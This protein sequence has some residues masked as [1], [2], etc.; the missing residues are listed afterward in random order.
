MPKKHNRTTFSEDIFK[1]V[2]LIWFQITRK[3]RLIVH[4]SNPVHI[5]A[6]QKI[7][8]YLSI[9]SNEKVLKLSLKY[10]KCELFTKHYNDISKFLNLKMVSDKENVDPKDKLLN[11]A[12]VFSTYTEFCERLKQLNDLCFDKL[13]E[14]DPSNTDTYIEPLKYDPIFA[15]EI[16]DYVKKSLHNL[17]I[18]VPV[19][20]T[21]FIDGKKFKVYQNIG[22]G[23]CIPGALAILIF[24]HSSFHAITRLMICYSLLRIY[25]PRG[26]SLT[27]QRMGH[28]SHAAYIDNSDLMPF[29]EMFGFNI[30]NY[31]FDKT[32]KKHEEIDET[33]TES[34]QIPVEFYPVES[35]HSLRLYWENNGDKTHHIYPI[36]E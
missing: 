2:A 8:R 1:N 27:K 9:N 24:G 18:R 6:V 30:Y 19:F 13:K 23:E 11:N 26:R 10:V 4:T 33:Q 28:K 3:R 35:G 15:E 12:N 7:C 17:R 5:S 22:S 34:K 36:A 14:A 21:L 20:K 25:N 29:G 31:Y 32:R 16:K